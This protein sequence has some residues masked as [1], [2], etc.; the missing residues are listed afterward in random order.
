MRFTAEDELELIDHL[1]E[2]FTP[3]GGRDRRGQVH[4]E[5]ETALT[6]RC[7][8]TGTQ[9]ADLDEHFLAMFTPPGHIA[10]DGV[11]HARIETED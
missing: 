2:T 9:A 5:W 3:A 7:G 8:F 10:H 6:C 1:L 11:K 4:V